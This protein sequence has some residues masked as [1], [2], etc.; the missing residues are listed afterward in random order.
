MNCNWA[1]HRPSTRT[2]FSFEEQDKVYWPGDFSKSTNSRVSSPVR[3]YTS[4]NQLCFKDLGDGRR[5]HLNKVAQS[6]ETVDIKFALHLVKEA[7]WHICVRDIFRMVPDFLYE[8]QLFA[9]KRPPIQAIFLQAVSPMLLAYSIDM[10]ILFDCLRLFCLYLH[11]LFFA[12]HSRSAG[13][14]AHAMST[15]FFKIHNSELQT[16]VLPSESECWLWRV[17]KLLA[18]RTKLIWLH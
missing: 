6:E 9:I 10:H 7:Q 18:K 12:F 16:L 5:A 1:S 3:I 13:T 17:L 2:S 15:R 4:A 11:W 8:S 14:I